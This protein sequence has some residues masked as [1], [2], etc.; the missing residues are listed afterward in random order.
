MAQV[1]E[2]LPIGLTPSTEKKMMVKVELDYI[3][4]QNYLT[5]FNLT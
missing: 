2:Y 4:T 5:E 3:F 1:A